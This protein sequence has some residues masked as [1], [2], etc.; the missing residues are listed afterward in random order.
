MSKEGFSAIGYKHEY[1]KHYIIILFG[2]LSQISNAQHLEY[3]VVNDYLKYNTAIGLTIHLFH[4]S[5]NESLLERNNF[6]AFNRD[7]FKIKN[8]ILFTENE[9]KAVDSIF[10]GIDTTF[11]ISQIKQY[12]N[13]KWEKDSLLPNVSL[14]KKNNRLNEVEIHALS[15]PIFTNSKKEF[16]F[17]HDLEYDFGMIYILSKE[18]NKWVVKFE[19]VTYMY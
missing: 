6:L 17:I 19:T 1:M 7:D 15:F 2:L 5:V 12:S 8:F 14:F 9:E 11:M 3:E 13:F 16:A 4:R 10:D 18:R